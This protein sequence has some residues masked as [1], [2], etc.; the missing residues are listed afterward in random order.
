MTE[1]LLKAIKKHNSNK[2]VKENENL[3]LSVNIEAGK[4]YTPEEEIE[5]EKTLKE[6]QKELK[7]YLEEEMKGTVISLLKDIK[8]FNTEN[9]E[10]K[11]KLSSISDEKV[12]EK[13]KGKI[14]KKQFHKFNV[15][16]LKALNDAFNEHKEEAKHN[17]KVLKSKTI[18]IDEGIE[19]PE[20][21]EEIISK[22]KEI[23]SSPKFP[24]SIRLYG[25]DVQDKFDFASGK[26]YSLKDIKE[27]VIKEYFELKKAEF[28]YDK[29]R[30]SVYITMSSSEKG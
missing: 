10:F 19:V 1:K 25:D 7:G 16:E 8:A 28:E 15:K 30:N 5:I 13:I 12:L 27:I 22:A 4:E 18:L 21:E 11:F 6:V 26:R 20:S 14:T 29:E 17:E 2:F 23:L 3:E 24:F 9:G